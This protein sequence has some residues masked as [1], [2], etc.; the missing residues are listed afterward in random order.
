MKPDPALKFS[1]FIAASIDGFIARPDGALDWLPADGD[2]EGGDFG[3]SDFLASVDT[4][5]MGRHTYEK[6]LSF[7]V[8]WPFDG[9]RVV[10][11]SSQ[12]PNIPAPLAGRVTW[13]AGDPHRI[14]AQLAAEGAQHV[15]IDGGTTIQAFLRARLIRRLTLT[16]V[17]VLLGAGIPLFGPV[18]YDLPL[19]H[20]R[21][22]SYSNGVVQ[23][24]YAA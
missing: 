15:Y 13:L 17:P 22:V 6:L 21:T 3:F 7:D 8:G 23:S 2:A 10:I 1:V 14:A 11:L 5:V 20:L 24:D 19:Q 4:V 12:T 9:K 18:A 16:R